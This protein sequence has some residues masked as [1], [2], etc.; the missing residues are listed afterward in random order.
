MRI[1]TAILMACFVFVTSPVRAQMDR[2][3]SSP[4]QQGVSSGELSA[5]IE[6]VD[7][8]IDTMN[9]FMLVRHGHVVAEA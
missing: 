7:S 3:R 8:T 5:F 2:P 6:D 4:E 9:S 1:F